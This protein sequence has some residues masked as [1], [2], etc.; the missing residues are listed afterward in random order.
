MTSTTA[1][2]SPSGRA[3]RGFVPALLAAAF[4]IAVW[5]VAAMVV[6]HDFLLA[7]PAQVVERLGQLVVTSGFWVIVATSLTRI[8][9][10]FTAAAIVGAALAAL[11][12]A[13]R[14]A[15]ILASPLIATI[16]SAPVVS[17]IILLLLWTDSSHLA[18]YTSFLMVLP[19]MYA[20]ILAGIRNRDRAL[21]EFATV[22]RV[23]RLRRIRA[24]DVPAVLP[25]LSA[26]CRTGVGLA[27]KSGVAAEVIGVAQGSIGER[28]YQAKLFLES[29]DL[30]AWTVVIITLSVAGEA[31]VL[32]G[33][34]RAQARF[35]G[36]PT[37][38]EATP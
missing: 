7:S 5:Q 20:N 38:A 14:V 35:A 32:W 19:V 22:F 17:F 24:I 28:L 34:R 2:R 21:L 27:W 15:E 4:W 36:A 1:A 23:P 10:G 29:A 18:A 37:H 16:R 30:F 9:V 25:F 31:F 6:H 26:A 33:L 11:S 12:S 13:S 3:A 8:I